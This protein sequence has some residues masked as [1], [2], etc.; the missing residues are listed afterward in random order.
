MTAIPSLI[1]KLE[2]EQLDIETLISDP[3]FYSNDKDKIEQTLKQLANIQAQLEQAF[4]R[5]EELEQLK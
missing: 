1:E 2:S 3:D 5:W 4:L